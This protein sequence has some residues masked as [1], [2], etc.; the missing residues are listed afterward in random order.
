M[1]GEKYSL[2]NLAKPE[3]KRFLG[4]LRDVYLRR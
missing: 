3:D 4:T 2:W 1:D